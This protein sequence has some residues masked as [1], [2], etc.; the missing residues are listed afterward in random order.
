VIAVYVKG[1][2][3]AGVSVAPVVPSS[4]VYQKP[5]RPPQ[6]RIAPPVPVMPSMSV[7]G[8]G[9]GVAVAAPPLELLL[10]VPPLELVELVVPPLLEALLV[11]ELLVPAPLELL[12]LVLPVLEPPLL[13]MAVSPPELLLDPPPSSEK[14]LLNPGDA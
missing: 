7:P 9:Q 3:A 12:L 11:A 10:V 6:L 1:A 2:I 8:A 14:P 13:S 4:Y 5:V